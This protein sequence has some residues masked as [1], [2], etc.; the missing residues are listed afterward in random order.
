MK[1]Q[2]SKFRR[3]VANTRT[4]ETESK[5]LSELEK[6]RKEN[7]DGHNQTKL[8]LTKLLNARTER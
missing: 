8:S 4:H 2:S 5:I 3:V 7:V 1:A 6:L